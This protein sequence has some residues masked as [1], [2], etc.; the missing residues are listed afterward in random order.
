M[1]GALLNSQQLGLFVQ[2]LYQIGAIN[3]PC[4]WRRDI[5]WLLWPGE[6]LAVDCWGKG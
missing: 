3:V 1:A 4:G 6:L 2:D 5:R